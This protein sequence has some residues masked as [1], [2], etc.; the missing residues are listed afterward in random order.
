[1]NRVFTSK[2]TFHRRFSLLNNLFRFEKSEFDHMQVLSNQL[3]LQ[4]DSG[5][6]EYCVI[7]PLRY[8]SYGKA[9][10]WHPWWVSK[11]KEISRATWIESVIGSDILSHAQNPVLQLERKALCRCTT[12][13]GQQI[14]LV[15]V[16]SFGGMFAIANAWLRILKI[17]PF[18]GSEMNIFCFCK[19]LVAVG[20]ITDCQVSGRG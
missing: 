19:A 15:V 5:M 2:I 11:E 16:N 9:P 8:D 13:Q 1:M 14:Q 12:C 18:F 7:D 20:E 10:K 6:I 4:W 17:I 3:K